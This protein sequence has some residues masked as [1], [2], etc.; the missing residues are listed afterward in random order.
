MMHYVTYI[1]KCSDGTYYTGWTNDLKKRIETHN[2]GKGAKYTRARCPVQLLTFWTFD[3]KSEA[4]QWEWQLKQLS[5]PQKE[6]QI[7]ERIKEQEKQRKI[8]TQ[9]P[10]D[11]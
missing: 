3:S 9:Q 7:K 4:M 2:K 5:R 6:G 8:Q 10:F 1:L 11:L